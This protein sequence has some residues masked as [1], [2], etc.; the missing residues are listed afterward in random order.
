MPDNYWPDLGRELP[1]GVDIFWTGNSVCAESVSVA[2]V[3]VV[4]G[5]LG[6][7]V[8]LWDNYPVNDGAV[9]SNSLYLE[10]LPNR[11]A[12]LRDCLTGHLCNPMNQGMLSLPAL[13]GLA[14]L[15]GDGERARGWVQEKLG[16]ATWRQLQEDREEFL[17]QG[18]SGMG[19]TRCAELADC[20]QGLPGPAAAEVVAWLNGEYTWD[21]ACL[22]D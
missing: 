6:R 12:G 20:Y 16:A 3:R 13:L 1:S 15:Y 4:E 8:L 7:P 14:D 11:E 9:R 10:A 22:T 19:T 5:Q 18:L 2:D 21:P 17:H